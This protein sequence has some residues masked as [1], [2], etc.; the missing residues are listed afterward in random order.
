MQPY[1]VDPYSC[2]MCSLYIHAY[3]LYLPGIIYMIRLTYG[4]S[5]DQ[6]GIIVT[7]LVL[8]VVS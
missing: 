6:T 1:P 3:V 5:M 4:K 2:Y 7:N 8:L